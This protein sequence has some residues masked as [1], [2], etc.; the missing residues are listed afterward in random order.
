MTTQDTVTQ[1]MEQSAA[2]RLR[3]LAGG[4]KSGIAHPD[5]VAGKTG[6]EIM[7]AMLARVLL[8]RHRRG[9]HH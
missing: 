3:M 6:M 8:A 9:P 4:G 5:A 7:Q 1:W 2:V